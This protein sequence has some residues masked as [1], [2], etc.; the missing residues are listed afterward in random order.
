MLGFLNT[1]MYCSSND[2]VMR[3]ELFIQS[4]LD[5]DMGTGLNTKSKVWMVY[6]RKNRRENGNVDVAAGIS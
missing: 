5:R 6:V 4:G 1:S 2:P 3:S